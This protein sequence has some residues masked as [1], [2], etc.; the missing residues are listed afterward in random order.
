LGVLA[1]AATGAGGFILTPKG[2][3]E[4]YKNA[5]KY[6][7]ALGAGFMLAVAF[8]ELLPKIIELWKELP[9]ADF[10]TPMALILA[11]YL[12]TQFFEHT[13]APHFHMGEEIKKDSLISYSSAYV[14]LGGF[15]I[16]TFLD[17]VSIAA[18]YKVE[19]QVGWLV[20]FAV[21]L[22]KIPEGFTIASLL[23]A[24][25]RSLKEALI[26]ANVVGL[27]T[28]LGVIAFLLFGQA[29]GFSVHFALPLAGGVMIYV[30][31]SDLIPEINHHG[32]K[33]P[34]VSIFVF[35]G[36]A[37]FFLMHY[38]FHILSEH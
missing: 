20:F 30:A 16:H 31:A 4:R 24:A 6:L 32:G 36:V 38:L 5:F 21:L 37:L 3:Y 34:L 29:V 19:P 13:I 12:L 2:L 23:L 18:A 33:R 22:H 11:G 28:L 25:G 27:T 8:L 1:A 26:A 15:L 7:I 17:G 10:L 9:T 14:A 35:A